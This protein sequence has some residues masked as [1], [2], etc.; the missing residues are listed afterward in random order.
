MLSTEAVQKGVEIMQKIDKSLQSPEK[1]DS[2]L[3]SE[4]MNNRAKTMQGTETRLEGEKRGSASHH[5]ISSA[6][7]DKLSK[8][9]NRASFSGFQTASG[10]SV[11]L[12]SE[13]LQKAVSIMKQMDKSPTKGNCAPYSKSTG[14]F[15]G[16]QTTSG[17]SVNMSRGAMEKG[18]TIMQEI[19]KSFDESK[20]NVTSCQSGKTSFTGC[21]TASGQRVTLEKGTAIMQQI[22][23]SLEESKDNTTSFQRIKTGFSGFQTSSGQKVTFS[24]EALEKGTAIMQQIDRSLSESQ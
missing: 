12:S 22:D 16:F 9:E 19:E 14:G 13:A 1:E 2:E 18:A 15:S 4:S 11:T 3:S 10:K 7:D 24:K 6:M 23:R 20:V 8:E 5:P 21:Q 17:I